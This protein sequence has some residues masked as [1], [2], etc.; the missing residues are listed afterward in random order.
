MAITGGT[1]SAPLSPDLT[2]EVGSYAVAIPAGAGVVQLI[3]P[4]VA[5][6]SATIYN[7]TRNLIRATITFSIG[8]LTTGLAATRCKLIP[9]GGTDTIDFSDHDGDNAV[10]AIDAIDSISFVAV[11][12]GTTTAE[13][14]T[15]GL[16]TTA[17]PAFAGNLYVNLASA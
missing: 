7:P 4:S 6:Q 1:F 15:L 10:G 8:I 13:A 14:S 17:D 12:P 9:P 11:M 16:T 5:F 3:D 2:K